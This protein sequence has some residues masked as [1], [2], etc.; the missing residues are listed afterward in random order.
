MS[1]L[2]QER[3]R[4]RLEPVVYAELRKQVIERDSWRCRNCGTAD[5]LQVHHRN[6]R[7]RMGNDC[8]ENLIT[9]CVSCH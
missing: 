5:N 9:L 7:S 8:L 2:I 3:L 4:P 6:W 1:G